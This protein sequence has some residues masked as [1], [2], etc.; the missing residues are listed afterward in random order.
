PDVDAVYMEAVQM[1][2]GQGGWPLNVFLTPDRRPFFGGTYWP[3]SPRYGMKS[4][5]QVLQSIALA[6]RDRREQVVQSAAQIVEHLSR[7]PRKSQDS[8]LNPQL[9]AEGFR[10]IV[11]QF[12]RQHGGFGVAPKFPQPLTLEFALRYSQRDKD[13]EALGVVRKTLEEMAAG[14]M[15]D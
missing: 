8:N 5:T 12:D 13:S 6:W 7:S 1:M 14:G 3:A 2:T 11:A 10:S 9:L 4:W 15:Y